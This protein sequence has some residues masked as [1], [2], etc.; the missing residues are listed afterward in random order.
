MG[1]TLGGN[2][3][4]GYDLLKTS[5]KPEGLLHCRNAEASSVSEHK[6][7]YITYLL[8]LE[9]TLPNHQWPWPQQKTTISQFRLFLRQPHVSKHEQGLMTP[10]EKTN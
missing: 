7:S 10:K 3:R 5:K 4:I 6:I 1:V 9:L 2:A 8:V